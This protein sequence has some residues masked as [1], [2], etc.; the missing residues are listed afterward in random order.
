MSLG[1]ALEQ[2]ALFLKGSPI[3]RGDVR[4]IGL[5]G[6]HY[7]LYYVEVG[8]RVLV[9]ALFHTKTDPGTYSARIQ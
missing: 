4:R 6:F 1:K 8:G 2:I 3:F 9:V 5:K 7:R